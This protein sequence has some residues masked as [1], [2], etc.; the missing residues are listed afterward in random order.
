ML[1]EKM[2]SVFKNNMATFFVLFSLML[3]I[4]VMTSDGHRYTSDEDWAQLQAKRIATLT[5]HPLWVENETRPLYEHP[6]IYP[7]QFQTGEICNNFLLCSPASIGHSLTEVPFLLIN[8]NFNIIKEDTV[9]WTFDDFK[10]A[11]YIM[12]RNSAEPNFTFLEIFYGPIFSAFAVSLF[13]LIC[14]TFD[15]NNK[16]SLSLALIFALSTTVW[17][18]SQTSLNIMPV[19]SFVLLSYLLFRKFEKT[20]RIKFLIFSGVIAGFGFLVR[21]DMILFIIPVF[22]YLL[23]F[24]IKRKFQVKHFFS[25][26]SVVFPFYIIHQEIH[27]INYKTNTTAQLEGVSSTMSLVRHVNLEWVY[28]LLFSPGVGLFVFSPILLTAFV[29]FCDFYNKNKSS[30]IL[31]ISIAFTYIIY[32]GSFLHWHGLVSWGSRYLVEIMP[33]LLIPL[34]ASFQKRRSSVFKIFII[35]LLIM[36]FVANLSFIT[37]DVSWFVWGRPGYELG[38]YGLGTSQTALYIHEATKWS[39][40]YSQLT[41]SIM[42]MVQAIQPDIY[43]LKILGLTNYVVLFYI[44]S[45]PH[46]FYLYKLIKIEKN[47]INKK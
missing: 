7:P 31:F 20:N 33:F 4:F 47:I 28:G 43:S 1:M 30:T 17:A 12:W 37:Q 23:I 36:G 8:E 45:I 18:Y 34:G 38:L 41:H 14:R 26:V 22:V 32:Y 2:K 24:T 44:L 3:I 19:T 16:I 27:R 29:S 42:S 6:Q 21:L 13:F 9:T 35:L 15:Y 5:P 46:L 10:D 11:H 25:Y 40:E 39:F